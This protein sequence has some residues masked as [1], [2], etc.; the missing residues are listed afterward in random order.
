MTYSRARGP[1]LPFLL[2]LLSARSSSLQGSWKMDRREVAQFCKQVQISHHPQLLSPLW[3]LSLGWGFLLDTH[4]PQVPGV[5]PS[6]EAHADMCTR[7]S[8][9]FSSNAIRNEHSI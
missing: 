3:A 6:L 7:A 4:G 8:H 9:P 1:H 5:E 2:H